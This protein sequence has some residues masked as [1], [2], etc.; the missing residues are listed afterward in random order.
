MNQ[1][2]RAYVMEVEK[3]SRGPRIILSRNHR[4]M[5]RRLMELEVPEIFNGAVEIKAIA[6]EPGARSKVAVSA[7]RAGVDPVGSC[8]GMRG[9][10]IQGIVN[11][12]SGEKI[13]VVEWN[14]D[15][16]TFISNALSPAQVVKVHLAET[17]DG[18][19]ATVI[20][21]DKQLSLAI[22]K[23]GQNARLAAKLTGWRIDIKSASEAAEEVFAFPEPMVKST[24]EAERDLLARAEAILS[25]QLAEEASL[26]R[27]LE[28]EVQIGR[29]S[30]ELVPTSADAV[31]EA[32]DDVEAEET[33]EDEI[34]IAEA[35][36]AGEEVEVV[37]EEI[38]DQDVPEDEV[39]PE[40][41]YDEELDEVYADEVDEE[42][43]DEDIDVVD[44]EEEFAQWSD[45]DED[46][47]E[48]TGGRKKRKH[49]NK[50]HALVFDENAGKV[51]AKRKRKPSRRQDVWGEDDD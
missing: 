28:A 41:E 5:L 1:R 22:G 8:V 34:A 35:E 48:E 32:V 6:R 25:A 21:P 23:E 49:W 29:E 47:E 14:A 42:V 11:E 7:L 30:E 24:E 18:K 45:S 39:E 10:R 51:V 17:T 38:E 33:T 9:T 26:E 3:S 27:A 36:E 4:N 13:D 40:E 12:L 19:T 44:I 43:V 37:A 15:L 50:K 31:S 46:E 2:L 20:V 16:G